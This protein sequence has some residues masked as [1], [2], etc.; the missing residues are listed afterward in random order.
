MTYSQTGSLVRTAQEAL[1]AASDT[2]R[3]I[4]AAAG[5]E[6]TS[7]ARATAPMSPIGTR[8]SPSGALKASYRTI[9]PH[10]TA[11]PTHGASGWASGVESSDPAALWTEFGVSAQT[12]TAKH[13]TWVVFR[14]WP[15][16]KLVRAKLVTQRGYPGKY[17]VAGALAATEANLP[18]LAEPA[19]R[20]WAERAERAAD[21]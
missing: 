10:L 9:E 20:A 14:R 18:E 5:E 4:V 1:D 21:G 15:D 2:V 16:V 13:A 7:I 11:D 19:I 8:L 12:V 17:I 6:A 3:D